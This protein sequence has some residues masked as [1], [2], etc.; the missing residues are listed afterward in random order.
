MNISNA[1]AADAPAPRNE[2][3]LDL[4][5]HSLTIPLDPGSNQLAI[6]KLEESVSLDSGYAPAW[7]E[8]GLRYY[9]DY[10]LWKSG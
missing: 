2:Q 8:L 7:G 1:S 6:Q 5:L 4:F 3:A 9:N 10:H